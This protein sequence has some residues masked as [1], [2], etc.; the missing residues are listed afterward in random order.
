MNHRL[1]NLSIHR[2]PDAP[3]S[4]GSDD[5]DRLLRDWHDENTA[6]ARAG[7]DRLLESVTAEDAPPTKSPQLIEFSARPILEGRSGAPVAAG[8]VP[9]MILASEGGGGGASS[10]RE[11]KR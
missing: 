1:F 11:Y 3:G 6:S 2:A 4:G 8:K 7:R 9:L 5:L 10:R